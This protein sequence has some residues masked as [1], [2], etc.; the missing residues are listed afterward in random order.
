MDTDDR[1]EPK[2]GKEFVAQW[3]EAIDCAGKE[4]ETWR[5]AA[6]KAEKAYRG[7]SLKE[8]NIFHSNIETLFPSIYNALPVP[9]VRRRFNDDDETGQLAANLI[10]RA[11]SYTIDDYDFDSVMSSAVYNMIIAGRGVVRVKYDADIND[12]G[13]KKYEEVQC[14]ICPW[15][16]FRHGAARSWNKVPWVAFEHFLTRDQL[17]KIGA[18]LPQDFKFNYSASH[19]DSDG[20]NTHELEIK[21]TRC[22]RVWEIWDKNTKKVIFIS[23]DYRDD[24]LLNENDPLGLEGFFPIPRPI[25]ALTAAGELTPICP[26]FVYEGLLDSLDVISRRIKELVKQ[27]RARGAFVGNFKE[28]TKIAEAGDGVL[29]PLASDGLEGAVAGGA[30]DLNKAISWFPLEQ[31]VSALRELI[32]QR[33]IIKQQIYEAT[34]ISDIVRG[35]T[36]ASE[37]AT[38]Q[39]IKSS[40]AS[41]RLQKMQ[42]EV[43]RFARDIFR[44]K[45]EIM[46]K[47]FSPETW[48]KITGIKL[49]SDAEKAQIQAILQQ[50]PQQ[51]AAMAQQNPAAVKAYKQPSLEAVMSLLQSHESRE[52][53]VDI[54][55]DSTI[56]GDVQRLQAQSAAFLAGTTQFLT[57]VAPLVQQG[58]V[59]APVAIEL[60]QA[61]AGDQKMSK[62]MSDTLGKLKEQAEQA[63]PALMQR[64]KAE[65]EGEKGAGEQQPSPA[66]QAKAQAMMQK[67]AIDGQKAQ[68]ELQIKGQALALKKYEIDGNLALK[69]RQQDMTFAARVPAKTGYGQ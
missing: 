60:Y 61:F 32:A 18:K 25:Q 6:E 30:F 54:E 4:D 36:K 33:E 59:P 17:K 11:L 49:M 38:A 69:Q 64:G 7:E 5:K 43:A 42:G 50:N 22:A 26:Y 34:G 44:L 55:T 51:A 14:E 24:A 21:S 45:A 63:G 2:G 29:V 35:A 12:A 13:L 16:S 37:T 57:A 52:Y 67:V 46:C 40:W 27:V 53:R 58:I 41:L 8:F 23:P 9:D 47:Q 15:E 19:K 48:I 68:G 10:E 66:D 3:L 28:L 1:A 62:S 39:N 31:T 65:Q 56:R 20:Q